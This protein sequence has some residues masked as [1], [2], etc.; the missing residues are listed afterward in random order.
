MSR[1]RG[2]FVSVPEVLACKA[3]QGTLR[4]T[5]KQVITRKNISLFKRTTQPLL[6]A[7]EQYHVG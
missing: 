5:Q 4:I 7:M 3:L 2:Y 6:E 1:V